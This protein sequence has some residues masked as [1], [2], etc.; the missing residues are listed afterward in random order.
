MI[1]TNVLKRVLHLGLNG[2]TATGFLLDHGGRQYLVTAAHFIDVKSVGQMVIDIMHDE[3]W[4][5]VVATIVG[6]GQYG[7]DITVL[8]LPYRIASPELRLDTSPMLTVTENVYFV[9]F[10]YGLYS[11]V[12]PMNENYP[13]PFVKRAMISA[14]N[15]GGRPAIIYLDGQNNPGFSG[16]PVVRK[17]EVTSQFEVIAVISGY[18]FAP[19]PVRVQGMDHPELEV[20]LNSGI[21]VTY[22][23]LHAIQIIEANPI[24]AQQ[25]TRP[26]F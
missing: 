3:Q 24:G 11:H 23:I 16:G 8:A 7:A 18:R 21:V 1:T 15:T 26:G 14:F 12:G 22:N 17:N 5:K 2:G 13:I 19:M 4:K 6:H 20:R 25:P 9:G 10:P